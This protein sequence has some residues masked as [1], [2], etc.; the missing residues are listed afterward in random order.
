[1]QLFLKKITVICY[2]IQ[3]LLIIL[4]NILETYSSYITTLQLANFREGNEE[5]F[6]YFFKT[7]YPSLCFFANKYTKNYP[8][9]EEIV[10]DSFIKV[11][12]KREGFLN[13]IALRSYLYKTVY[14]GALRWL[15]KEKKYN[16]VIA[17][18][19]LVTDEN[20]YVANTIKAET[21]RELHI[22]I[23]ELPPQCRKIFTK[24]YIEGK[25]TKETAA[26][27]GLAYS[28]IKAQKAR[29]LSLIKLKLGHNYSGS[30]LTLFFL[31]QDYSN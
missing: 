1:M 31:L 19:N 5:G 28:T 8:A 3:K 9:A 13:A 21:L 25:T 20:L 2:R 26:E 18:Q 6:N 30:L 24:L 29:G 22:V 23:N 16:I 14:H 7:L 17:Q 12:D 11:W 27:L 15:E 10:N 4:D